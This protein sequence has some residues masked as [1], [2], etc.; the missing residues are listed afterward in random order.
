L[1]S[2]QD[3]WKLLHSFACLAPRRSALDLARSL[4][5]FFECRVPE[6]PHALCRVTGIWCSVPPAPCLI[7]DC[8]NVEVLRTAKGTV[9]PSTTTREELSPGWL[10]SEILSTSS[11]S[12][13]VT[14]LGSRIPHQMIMQ[15]VDFSSDCVE[16]ILAPTFWPSPQ[17][18]RVNHVPRLKVHRLFTAT[19]DLHC[20]KSFAP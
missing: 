6:N 19:I 15:H 2:R 11:S 8:R 14:W 4:N 20:N 1:D 3:Q 17:P 9:L 16:G 12:S 18:W 5:T 13:S 7:L 10:T